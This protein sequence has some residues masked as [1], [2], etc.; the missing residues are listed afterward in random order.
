MIAHIK[1][2]QQ[3]TGRVQAPPSKSMAHRAVLCA[4]L[5]KGISRLH[6]LEFS[7]DIQA[8]L[9][10]AA[11]M[12]AKVEPQ[13]QGAVITGQSTVG[14]V[15]GPV[16]CCESGSTLRFLVPLLSLGGGSVE[17]T[18]RGRLFQRPMEVYRTLFESQGLRFEQTDHSLTVEGALKP[19][20]YTLRGDVSSQF[21]TGLMYTLALLKEDSTITIQ[22]PFESRSYVELTRSAMARFGVQTSW[23]DDQRTQLR[24]PGGQ[25]FVPQD[26]QVEGDYSQAA[27]FAV[28]AAVKGGISLAGL[29]PDSLQGDKAILPILRDCGACW[30]WQEGELVFQ[31]APL[32]ATT[33][34][35]ADCPDLGPILMVLAVFC[36]GTT[37][38]I[39]AQRLR[40]K[41]SDRIAAMEQELSKLGAVIHSTQ[42]T[43][44]IQGGLLHAPSQPLQSHNDHRVVMALSVAALCAGIPV[45][46][47]GAQAVEKSWPTF[48]DV[49]GATGAQLEVKP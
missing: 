5:A 29:A 30:Q 41:E 26:Y 22:P 11:Q 25:P 34:D 16:D 18:G 19:G 45:E 43:V 32:T 27:F 37:R 14:R 42:D 47:E 2:T 13:P 49:L 46:I 6:H 15:C 17:F 7:R 33:I 40:M 8:T 39:N 1:P 36:Q 23:L 20:D 21:I 35:L 48:F 4:A 28:L 12:G 38:I 9:G 31:P 3:L 24:I 44:T 10:A